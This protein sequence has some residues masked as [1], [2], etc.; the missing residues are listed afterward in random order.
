MTGRKQRKRE[1]GDIVRGERQ[2]EKRTHKKRGKKEEKKR[3]KKRG[4]GW[5]GGAG[6]DRKRGRGERLEGKHEETEKG[7]LEG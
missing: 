5:G 7:R 4:G 3:R 1:R 2:K 6:A